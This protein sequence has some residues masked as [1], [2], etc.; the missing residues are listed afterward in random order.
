VEVYEDGSPKLDAARS[1]SMADTEV[2][3]GAKRAE[4][5]IEFDI[6]PS[7]LSSKSGATWPYVDGSI[8]LKGRN[9]TSFSRK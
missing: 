5:G 6:D 4:V 7:E 8:N 9:V 2:L 1:R 3:T